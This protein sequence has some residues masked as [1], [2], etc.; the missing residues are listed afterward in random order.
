M[1][2]DFLKKR[3]AELLRRRGYKL[4]RI[5]V[6]GY[7][8]EDALALALQDVSG[9][10]PF[11]IDIGAHK[12]DFFVPVLAK[13]PEAK[14]FAFEPIPDLAA[15]LRAR[16]AQTP[17]L[18]VIEAATGEKAARVNFNVH[19]HVASSSILGVDKH[20]SETY[21]DQARVSQ[22]LSV[23]MTT[24]DDAMAAHSAD[25]GEVDILKIDVQGF[26]GP[27]LRGAER[28]LQR[29]TTV[30]VEAAL[31]PTYEGGIMA[32]ELCAMLRDRGFE[33][34]YAF[35]VYAASADLLFVRRRLSSK[36]TEHGR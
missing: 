19:S 35:N 24:V 34:A 11:V 31:L 3:L 32:D 26:E 8:F 9:R 15:A 30:I 4:H 25:D 20:Y 6:E 23:E 21:P 22:K 7:T 14:I 12:G 13:H 5:W 36:R 18:V 33:L 28:T 17:S 10:A 27:A 1:I 29:T 16:F 2:S